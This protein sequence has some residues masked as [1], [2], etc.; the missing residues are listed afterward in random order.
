MRSENLRIS[1]KRDNKELNNSK[2]TLIICLVSPYHPIANGQVERFNRDMRH[3][4]MTML[5]DTTD[6]VSY[7]KPLQ[8]AHNTALSNTRRI[9]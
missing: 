3:Y 2:I 5:D 8:F 1:N 9:I 6:W 4:L 7:L